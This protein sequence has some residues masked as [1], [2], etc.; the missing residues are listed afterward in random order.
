MDKDIRFPHL[1]QGT[2]ECLDQLRGQFAD[3]TDGIAQQERNIFDDYFPDGRIQ[4]GE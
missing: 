4:R 1:I 2:L 3:K